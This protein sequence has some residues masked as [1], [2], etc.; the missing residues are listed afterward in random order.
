MPCGSLG[1][2]LFDRY[3]GTNKP[4]IDFPFIPDT[5]LFRCPPA[6]SVAEIRDRFGWDPERRRILFSARMMPV[7]RPDLALAAFQAIAEERPNWD[8]VMLG[9]GPLRASLETCVPEHLRHRI[10]WTGFL[11]SPREIA[12]LYASCDLLLLP[13][14]H[15]PWG[16]VIVEAAAAGL[17]IVATDVVGAAPELIHPGRNG[18]LFPPG[19]L[20]RMIAALRATTLA[21]VI[22]SA[23]H[24]SLQVLDDWLAVSDPVAG[25]RTALVS[26]IS[27]SNLQQHLVGNAASP[28]RAIGQISLNAGG[29]RGA[30]SRISNERPR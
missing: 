23:K 9:D 3:G 7:K 6:A 12:G 30:R 21:N 29:E 5:L 11:N 13:S 8:L 27:F 4:S 15:E 17:A 2:A 16:V 14:D 18:Q 28:P 26:A 24:Q 1:K 10:T 22:D 20:T 25:F 19:D